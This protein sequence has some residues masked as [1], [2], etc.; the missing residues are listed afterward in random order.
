MNKKPIDTPSMLC[1][2]MCDIR[3]LRIICTANMD[4]YSTQ[5]TVSGDRKCAASR[6]CYKFEKLKEDTSA[7]F[8]YLL[9][10]HKMLSLSCFPEQE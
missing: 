10:S 7:D 5:L 1:L 6:F 4:D 3:S 9:A 2:Q 8:Y